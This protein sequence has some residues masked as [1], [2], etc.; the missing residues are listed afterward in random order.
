MDRGGERV[1]HSTP[2]TIPGQDGDELIVNS[3]ERIDA[4][5]PNTGKLL[6]HTGTERQTPIPSA[7]FHDGRS[8]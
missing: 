4:Y 2:V 1:S 7:V 5:D 6:W 8:T 3:S